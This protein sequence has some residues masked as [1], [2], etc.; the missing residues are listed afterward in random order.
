MPSFDIV[1]KVDLAEIDNSIQ[2][3]TR[4]LIQ[5]Y[6]FKGTGTQVQRNEQ[7]VSI[8]SSDEY[9]VKAAKDVFESK[10]VRRKVNLKSLEAGEV[11]PSAKGRA[12]LIFSIKEGIDQDRARE[13]VKKVKESKLKV[14][15]AIQGT[16]LRV[17]GKKRDELQEVIS[18][19][20]GLDFPLPLQF[21]NFRD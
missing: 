16:Q 3:A 10:L 6:D 18:L 13:I 21:E 17:T 7:E 4:E 9:K 1:S 12:K 15:T 8:E 11:Q 20:R 14:Q 5:R 2:Q 19:L